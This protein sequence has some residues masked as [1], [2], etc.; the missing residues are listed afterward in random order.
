MLLQGIFGA[1]AHSDYG[2][3]TLLKTDQ[4]PGLQIWSKGHFVDVPPRDGM[5]IVN[6]GDMLE[7]WPYRPPTWLQCFPHAALDRKERAAPWRRKVRASCAGMKQRHIAAI[8]TAL[9]TVES[10]SS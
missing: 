6:L 8:K 1:G 5:F 2:M 4:H 3:L 7:R 10:I 9:L